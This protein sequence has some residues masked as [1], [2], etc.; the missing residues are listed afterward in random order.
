MRWNAKEQTESPSLNCAAEHGE[1]KES[2]AIYTKILTV[3]SKAVNI[4]QL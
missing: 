2:S 3:K 1:S 4:L